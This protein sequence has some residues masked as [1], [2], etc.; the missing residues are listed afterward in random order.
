MAQS[1]K[2]HIY[3][4]A[5]YIKKLFEMTETQ[6]ENKKELWCELSKFKDY[7]QLTGAPLTVFAANFGILRKGNNDSDLI[8]KITFEFGARDFFGTQQEYYDFINFYYG[9]TENQVKIRE[10]ANTRLV[11]TLPD[12]AVTAQVQEDL[13]PLRAVGV[14]LEVA[15]VEYVIDY[16][17]TELLGFSYT[18]LLDLKYK[19]S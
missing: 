9:Y 6:Y 13:Q 14:N 2:P 1:L 17:Y 15:D 16:S 11:I 7:K 5:I 12:S 8:K 18:N 19:R 3:D 4:N 10:T